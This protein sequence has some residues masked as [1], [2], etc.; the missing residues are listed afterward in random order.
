MW[1]TPLLEKTFKAGAAIAAYRAVKFG[2]DDDHVIQAAAA[3]DSVIG[4]CGSVG[5]GA[6]ED[7]VDLILVGIGEITLAATLTR[8]AQ[9]TCDAAGKA[10]AASDGNTVIGKLMKSGVAGDVVP[11]LLHAA[12]D[13]D[14]AP[15]FQVDV[16]VSTAE[17]LALNTTPKTLVAAPAAGKILVPEMLQCW[18]DYASTAYDGIAANEDLVVRYTDGTGAIAMT[19]EATGFLDAS[20]DAFRLGSR[21]GSDIAPV[22]A[23]ALVLHMST[24][25]IATGNSPLKVRLH[26]RVLDATF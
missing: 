26:Y 21:P 10:V 7:Q 18:L 6:A 22:A 1:K 13:S 25:N 19:V 5:A 12:G 23:A 11:I 4:V 2:D 17:L 20:A 15:L 8:G 9:V 24:G 16:T 3:T 14:A